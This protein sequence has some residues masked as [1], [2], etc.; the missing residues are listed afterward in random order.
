MKPSN[1]YYKSLKWT[2]FNVLL[3]TTLGGC[4]TLNNGPLTYEF[5]DFDHLSASLGRITPKDLSSKGP[6]DTEVF[7]NLRLD[8]S[9]N[10]STIDIAI[11]KGVRRPPL[12]LIQH[13]NKSHKEAHILQAKRLASWGIA[14]A[15]LQQKNRNQWVTNGKK[16]YQL[17]KK[18]YKD[19]KIGNFRIDRRKIIL[20]GHSFGGSAVTIAA[21]SGAPVIGLI[22]LDPAVVA[23][24]VLE[25]MKKVRQPVMLIGADKKIFRSRRRQK[26]YQRILGSM[27]EISIRG[28]THDDAQYPSMFSIHAFGFDPYTDDSKRH[29]FLKAIT[30]TAISLSA[31]KGLE[32]AWK[33]FQDE[34]EA[35]NY[36]HAKRRSSKSK[37]AH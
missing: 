30:T 22:L 3:V 13:G 17:T 28:A 1:Q 16:I 34:I 18:I 24:S 8:F 26:F 20:M 32:F 37:R 19:G 35:G 31:T 4:N 25:Y 33:S 21:G 11:P 9:S 6:F 27:G 12:V 2:L 36:K 14:S 23:D 15:T 29:L 5:K 10:H 7:K